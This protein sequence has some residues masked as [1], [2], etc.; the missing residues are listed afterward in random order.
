MSFE[1]TTALERRGC[2]LYRELGQQALLWAFVDVF[3][4]TVL[5]C[6]G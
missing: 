2:T 1:L 5:L 4:W 3:R 6:F